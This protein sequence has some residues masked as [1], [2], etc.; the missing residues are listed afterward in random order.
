MKVKLLANIC[1]P[2]G[3]FLVGNTPDLEEK[4]AKGLING[5]YAIE[6]KTINIDEI[7]KEIEDTFFE[8]EDI[9]GNTE[10]LKQ[11]EPIKKTGSQ[12]VNANKKHTRR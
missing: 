6:I 4:I 8:K 10:E 12:I 5:G 9:K 7:K 2:E 11:P 1:C 3:S